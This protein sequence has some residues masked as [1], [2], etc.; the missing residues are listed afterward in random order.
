MGGISGLYSTLS[1]LPGVGLGYRIFYGTI[2][3]TTALLPSI[4]NQASPGVQGV[5]GSIAP[6]GFTP[7]E[8]SPF[9]STLPSFNDAN[10]VSYFD[11]SG[12]GSGGAC[13]AGGGGAG[14]RWVVEDLY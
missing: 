2:G 9:E 4:T 7:P 1:L 13:F 11:F 3:I 12:V 5:G 14:G 10:G 8:L 6:G